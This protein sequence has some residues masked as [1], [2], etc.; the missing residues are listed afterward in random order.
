LHLPEFMNDN[1]DCS[2]MPTTSASL[3]KVGSGVE[4]VLSE[5]VEQTLKSLSESQNDL[6]GVGKVGDHTLC[7]QDYR[8]ILIWAESQEIKPEAFFARLNAGTKSSS[9]TWLGTSVENGRL[10]GIYWNLTLLPTTHFELMESLPIKYLAIESECEGADPLSDFLSFP[11]NFDHAEELIVDLSR[12]PELLGL[13]CCYPGIK[14][15]DLSGT[16]RLTELYCMF[17]HLADLNLGMV[18]NLTRLVCG[19]TEISH[20]ELSLVPKLQY[21]DC[22]MTP[23]ARLDLTQASNLTALSCACRQISELDL[24]HVPKLTLLNCNGTQVDGLDLSCVPKLEVLKCSGTGIQS[25]SLHDVPDLKELECT[26]LRLTDLDIRP[27]RH[28]NTLK[29]DKAL[30]RLIQRPDQNF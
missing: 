20:L 25:L 13:S 27:L 18:P 16:P 11:D 7:Q 23:V 3:A 15:L 21:L 19:G 10:A 1:K 9:P 28:L 2:L 5:M 17:T 4:R 8:Q 6:S 14:H 24:S 12:L 30:T 26:R 22:C 29:Y